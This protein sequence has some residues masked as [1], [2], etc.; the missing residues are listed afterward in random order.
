MVYFFWFPPIIIFVILLLLLLVYIV[1][2]FTAAIFA[3]YLLVLSH[4]TLLM[5]TKFSPLTA[6]WKIY[7][8][9]STAPVSD[10]KTEDSV[11]KLVQ[12][13][14]RNAHTLMM[15]SLLI[16]LFSFNMVEV[17]TLKNPAAIMFIVFVINLVFIAAFLPAL[18]LGYTVIKSI[19]DALMHNS[20]TGE[21]NEK[22]VELPQAF[23]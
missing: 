20:W 6:I 23:P 11:K 13:L 17:A 22:G 9:L 10:A 12:L 1:S 19:F 8:D 21:S 2:R 14:F 18:K 3:T 4:F 5:F 7:D 16:T 15:N